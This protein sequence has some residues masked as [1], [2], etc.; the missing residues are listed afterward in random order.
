MLS[1]LVY[2][3]QNAAHQKLEWADA[4]G[5]FEV[6][7]QEAD[8]L[9]RTILP[10]SHLVAGKLVYVKSTGIIFEYVA[11]A[12]TA[13][14]TYADW[15][16]LVSGLTYVGRT[17]NLPLKAIDGQLF[18]VRMDVSGKDY[19]RLISWDESI[20][21]AASWVDLT[22]LGTTFFPASITTP[23]ITPNDFTITFNLPTNAAL[24]QEGTFG[25]RLSWEEDSTPATETIV[26]DV[27]PG[28]SARDIA[29]HL[30]AA[31]L[32]HLPTSEISA[33]QNG[34][35]LILQPRAGVPA[36]AP[37]Q[38][39]GPFAA[40]G[41]VPVSPTVGDWGVVTAPFQHGSDIVPTDATMLF[42]GTV[43]WIIE[44]PTVTGGITVDVQPGGNPALV[45]AALSFSGAGNM[46]Y[47]GTSSSHA[48][49]EYIAVTAPFTF[50]ATDPA[51]SITW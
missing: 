30:E 24:G 12:T 47:F 5:D 34:V 39:V 33:T 10:Q 16:P 25:F 51:V 37:V 17:G 40:N 28:M 13:T 11:D 48:Q 3:P 42:V 29:T 6:V 20:P 26:V 22:S 18:V 8:L 45:G 35:M 49:G 19:Y 15:K 31:F 14:G 50:P 23:I 21:P 43:G 41:D 46:A 36:I 38:D 1:K 2:D 7:E 4:R 44:R 27:H 9:D 32:R